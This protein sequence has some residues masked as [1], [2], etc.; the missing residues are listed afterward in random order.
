[1]FLSFFTLG[2]TVATEEVECETEVKKGEQP[3]ARDS[4]VQ[5]ETC[6]ET[7]W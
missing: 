4:S 5:L 6:V 1:M 7:N 3:A 2:D